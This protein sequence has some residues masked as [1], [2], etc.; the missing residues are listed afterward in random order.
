MKPIVPLSAATVLLFLSFSLQRP[1]VPLFMEEDLRASITEI[2]QAA[3]VLGLMGL[4]TAVPAGLLSDRIGRQIPAALG[5]LIWGA[6]L[7]LVAVAS[8]PSQVILSYALAGIGTVLFDASLTAL[9]GDISPK[10]ELGRSYGIYNAAVQVGFTVGPAA[11]AVIILESGYRDVFLAVSVLPAA[12]AALILV[13]RP[14]NTVS[15]V[16]DAVDPVAEQVS[17]HRNDAI[18]AGWVSTFSFGMLVAGISVLAPLYARLSGFDDFFIGVL[19][20]VQSV[21]GAFG[22]FTFAHRID[23]ARHIGLLTAGG[24]LLTSLSTAG[25]ALSSSWIWLLLMMG[26]FGV[27]GAL[28]FM[29]A[30]VGVARGTNVAN[31]GTAM[32][33]VSMSRYAGFMFGPWLGSIIVSSQSS[34]ATGYA[35][36]FF[37]LAAVSFVGTLLIILTGRIHR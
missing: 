16:T 13:S 2:G 33:F 32:G 29:S 9:V 28:T 11:G 5:A 26:V 22:L 37:A 25:F 18:W 6:A 12:A 24:L 4:F 15:Q 1:F 30:T 27:G 17:I 8:E 21:T 3:A 10:G 35:V 34:I 36:G 31:R 20:T 19:F 14:Q 23:T 7:A